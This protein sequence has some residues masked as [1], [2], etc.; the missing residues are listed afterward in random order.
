MSVDSVLLTIYC[1]GC[2]ETHEENLDDGTLLSVTSGEV[3]DLDILNT[4]L[5]DQGWR[6]DGEEHF[7]PSCFTVCPTFDPETRRCADDCDQGCGG[8]GYIESAGIFVME[9]LDYQEEEAPDG[10]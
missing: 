1:D 8:R 10:G 2:S 6:G 9:D 7:C 5:F 4:R 3:I